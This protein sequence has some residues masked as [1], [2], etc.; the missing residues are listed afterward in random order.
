MNKHSNYWFAAIYLTA[1]MCY[2]GIFYPTISQAVALLGGTIA[3][4][5][6]GILF[7]ILY[8]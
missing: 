7:Y 2:I 5:F 1:F 4:I 6:L 8:K 3:T